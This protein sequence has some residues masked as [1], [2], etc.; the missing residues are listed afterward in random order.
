MK[1]I[2]D[3]VRKAYRSQR[4]LEAKWRKQQLKSIL[5]LVN[6]NEK[7]LAEALSKD[8]N[9]P[10]LEASVFEFGLIRSA[11]QQALAHLDEWMQL[12]RTEPP[13][14]LKPLYNSYIQ[15]QPYGTVLILGAWNYPYQLT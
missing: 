13:V 2:V 9:K 8:L 14:Q 15:K 3:S 10:L 12:Q 6:E 1:A 7:E 5:R 11:V 4:T